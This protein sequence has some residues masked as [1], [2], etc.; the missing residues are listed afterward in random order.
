MPKTACR[1]QHKLNKKQ[2]CEI[3]KGYGFDGWDD[4]KHEFQLQELLITDRLLLKFI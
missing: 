2:S 1:F 4:E 3:Y